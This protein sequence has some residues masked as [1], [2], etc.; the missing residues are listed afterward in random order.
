MN[1]QHN[2]RQYN[3]TTMKT[4]STPVLLLHIVSEDFLFHSFHF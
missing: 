2:Q 3:R 4:V 1:S